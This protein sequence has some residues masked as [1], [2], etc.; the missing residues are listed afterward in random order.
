MSKMTIKDVD[1]KGKKCLTRVDFNVPMVDG[2]ITDENRIK[3]A[4]PTIKYLME[5]GAKV[6][7]CSHLGKPHNIFTP[8]F[9]LTKKEK[10]AVEALPAEEQAKAK[11][12]YIAK[13]LKND[14]KKFS[15]RPVADRLAEI[16]PGKVTFATDLVGEDAH[17]K[18]AALRD[19]ECVLLENTRFDAG[20]EKNS[21]ELCRKLADFCDIYVNDA[22]GT[23]HRAHATTAGIVQYG[24]APVAVSGFL[25]EKELKFLGEALDNPARP[26]V[27]ILG[28]AKV[29]D[30]IGVIDNLIG[31]CDALIIGGGMAYTFRRAM[32]YKVGNS[33]LEEDKIEL[34]KGL[35]EKAEK[36]GVKLMLP[37]DN[38]IA[39]AF[40][41][42]ANTKVVSGDIPDGW[43]GLDIGPRHRQGVHRGGHERQDR[44]LERTHGRV[45]DG[46]VRGRHQGG[47]GGSCGVRRGDHHRRRRQ[48]GGGRAARLCGQDDPHLYGRR[49][50]SR[51]PRRQSASRH[52]LPER[53]E[54]TMQNMGLRAGIGA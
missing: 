29:S 30:K 8:G 22:F 48:R 21:E 7:L 43:M 25:I 9:G 50:V 1:V 2:V 42:D 54:V 5:H 39:D 27:A 10:K 18:V 34:A 31:K 19:G 33:L 14:A 20:E 4:L 13:A 37:T 17:A 36:A 45:R 46:E 53:Q 11:E 32:G 6:I 44:G 49:R 24:F 41:N 38:I 23:A 26:F 51:V 15:L 28:G 16:F 3:G 40:S 12:E 35:M 52:R 47:R